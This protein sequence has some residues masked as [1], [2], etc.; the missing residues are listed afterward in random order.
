MF[1]NIFNWMLANVPGFMR[2]AVRW[3][4]D[5]L[6]SITNHIADRWR[7]LGT[8]L[9][10]WWPQLWFW[11]QQ[12]ADFATTFIQFMGW[13]ILVRI[14]QFVARKVSELESYLLFV[15]AQA[16]SLLSG[17]IAELRS[18]AVSAID[19]LTELV[20]KVREWVKYWLDK[21]SSTL[22]ALIHM[23]LHVLN[24][25]DVLA[26]W[27]VAAMWRAFLRLVRAQQ[28][29]IASWLTRESVV[30]TRWLSTEIENIILRWL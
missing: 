10:A 23:L 26:E 13:L 2:P 19:W 6:R 24:G 27:L 17:L 22:S 8:I 25:P 30:F 1:L 4:I 12:I 14:P 5:G 16:K 29:R 21:L 15:V 18:W 28:D 3:L 11:W 20:N 9:T 7:S